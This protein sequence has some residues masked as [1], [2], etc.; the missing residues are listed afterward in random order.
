MVRVVP[1]AQDCP[2]CNGKLLLLNVAQNQWKCTK[3]GR[4]VTLP[5]QTVRPSFSHRKCPFCSGSV[6]LSDASRNLWKC[7]KCGSEMT[8]PLSPSQDKKPSQIPP[9]WFLQKYGRL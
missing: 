8:K 4:K 3:C 7:E 5:G 9:R 1:T 6:R 2:V